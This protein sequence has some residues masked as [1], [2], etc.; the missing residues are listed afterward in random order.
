M[1]MS[2]NS[3]YIFSFLKQKITWSVFLDLFCIYAF[4]IFFLSTKQYIMN[5]KIHFYGEKYIFPIA[6]MFFIPRWRGKKSHC[7]QNQGNHSHKAQEKNVRQSPQHPFPKTQTQVLLA[8]PSQGMA[9]G[10]GNPAPGPNLEFSSMEPGGITLLWIFEVSLNTVAVYSLISNLQ[11][12][13]RIKLKGSLETLHF[14]KNGVFFPK[15]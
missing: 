2:H 10:V 13:S 4:V 11:V 6:E 3:R 12:N 7:L 9:L 15:R 8:R 14:F 1:Y 5:T